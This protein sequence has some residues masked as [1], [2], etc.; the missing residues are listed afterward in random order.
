MAWINGIKNPNLGLRLALVGPDE[1]R[2][3]RAYPTSIGDRTADPH[4][5]PTDGLQRGG[6]DDRMSIVRKRA[7]LPGRPTCVLRD[8]HG[9]RA[10]LVSPPHAAAIGKTSPS[11][12][13]S[14]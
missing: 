7:P 2:A 6:S 1:M 5:V 3:R 10:K 8:D 12:P 11:E 4:F 14:R 9:R 13:P